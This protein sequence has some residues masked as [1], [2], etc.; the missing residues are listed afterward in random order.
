MNQ[1]Y[2]RCYSLNLFFPYFQ[3]FPPNW[4]QWKILYCCKRH[5]NC[6]IHVISFFKDLTLSY[7]CS[8]CHHF[9]IFHIEKIHFHFGFALN[10][11]EI[12]NVK[13]RRKKKSIW[14]FT[15]L[16]LHFCNLTN[17]CWVVVLISAPVS[18]LNS[19]LNTP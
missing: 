4:K 3:L 5:H 6:S 18:C 11:I 7:C 14:I 13:R 19:S 15:G 1:I 2:R 17:I 16:S 12:E 10:A 9:V 8:V